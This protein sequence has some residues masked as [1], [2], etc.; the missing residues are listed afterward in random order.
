MIF[1]IDVPHS[2]AISIVFISLKS[3][4]LGLI[5]II[6]AQNL[7]DNYSDK[8]TTYPQCSEAYISYLKILQILF[9]LGIIVDTITLIY[10]YISK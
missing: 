5:L 7:N 8:D 2:K 6:K 9:I 1:A 4:V 10:F 3:M